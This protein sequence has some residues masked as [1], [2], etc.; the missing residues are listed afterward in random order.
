MYQYELLTVPS[1]PNFS[2][3]YQ[4]SALQNQGKLIFVGT[5]T[6]S[7]RYDALPFCQQ[8][9]TGKTRKFAAFQ[10]IN[11]FC[12]F[13]SCFHHFF[14]KIFS[15]ISSSAMFQ[16]LS[17]SIFSHLQYNMDVKLLKASAPSKSSLPW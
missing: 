7:L 4:P 3:F 12:H 17:I 14:E 15:C 16:R 10:L 2:V 9:S 8:I 13:Y 1:K 5:G 6:F 11:D